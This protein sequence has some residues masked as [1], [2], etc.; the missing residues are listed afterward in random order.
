MSSKDIFTLAFMYLRKEYG[1]KSQRELA[2]T[3]G[4]SEDTITQTQRYAKVLAQSVHESFSMVE[5]K[6]KKE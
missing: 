4:V 3:I 5:E 1:I 2:N 6:L